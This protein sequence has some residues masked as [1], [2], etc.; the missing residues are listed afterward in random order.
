ML[1]RSVGDSSCHPSGRK[2]AFSL[3]GAF[4]KSGGTISV[5]DVGGTPAGGV[6]PRAAVQPDLAR[7]AQEGGGEAFLLKDTDAFWRHLVVSIFGRRFE[8][9]VS[10]IIKKLVRE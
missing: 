2:E 4:N 9:D 7:V 8:Q 5:I 3:A 1:F 10:I 6:A